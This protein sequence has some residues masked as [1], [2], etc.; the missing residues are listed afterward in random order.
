MYVAPT[1][2]HGKALVKKVWPAY[3]GKKFQVCT[4]TGPM[5]LYNYWDEGSRSYYLFVGLTDGFPALRLDLHAS[6]PGQQAAHAAYTIPVGTM[7][8]EQVIFRG[9]DLGLRFWL[10][11]GDQVLVLP[12]QTGGAL[13]R[14]E[15]IVLT[16]VCSLKASYGGIPHFRQHEA[17][18]RTG[19]TGE[20]YAVAK[21]TLQQKGLLT[22]AGAVT[23]AGR[24]AREGCTARDLSGYRGSD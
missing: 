15:Q 18:K 16:A 1:N 12:E 21:G 17:T 20:A 24:N 22:A 10:H 19:I 2:P 4:I 13:T 9:K 7:L 14:A 8:I 3:T 23:P 6:N 11:A 5:R